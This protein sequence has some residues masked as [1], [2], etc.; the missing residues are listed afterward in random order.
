[1]RHLEYLAQRI[2]FTASPVR[3]ENTRIELPRGMYIDL[4]LSGPLDLGDVD[5]NPGMSGA[6][7]GTPTAFG[8]DASRTGTA[9]QSSVVLYYDGTG[10]IE[11][12]MPNGLADA[13]GLSFIPSEP[14]FFW[15]HVIN[16]ASARCWTTFRRTPIC[17][18][19]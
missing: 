14:V 12:I 18:S 13:A 2:R 9:S 3:D 7:P 10:G 6:A 5:M 1:M 15:W 8:L 4:R 17:G 16:P 19:V 11:R